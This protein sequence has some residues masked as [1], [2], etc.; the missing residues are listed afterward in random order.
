MAKRALVVGGTG[1]MQGVSLHLTQ[2]FESVTVIARSERRLKALEDVAPGVLH[3]V[4]LDYGDTAALRETVSSLAPL[5]LAVCW[6]HSA[7]PEAPYVVAEAGKPR[8][9]VHVLGSAAADPSRPDDGRRE[10][11]EAHTDMTYREVILG[12]V[13]EGGYS[14]WLTTAEISDGVVVAIESNKLRSVVGTVE[15]WSARP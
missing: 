7:A 15:P 11:F 8:V 5:D 9:Y 6:I 12:F 1:M 13:R 10:R 3:G 2:T 14:R 4:A